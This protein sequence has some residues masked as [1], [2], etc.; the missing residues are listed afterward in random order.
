VAEVRHFLEACRACELVERDDEPVIDCSDVANLAS[1]RV[2]ARD[3][4]TSGP[5]QNLF[6]RLWRRLV[7]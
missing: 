3:G 2:V 6:E 1:G 7:G 5:A 4:A